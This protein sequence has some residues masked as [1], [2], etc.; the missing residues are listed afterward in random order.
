MQLHER[1]LVP[2]K[3]SDYPLTGGKD[4]KTLIYYL[5]QVKRILGKPINMDAKSISEKLK[6]VMHYHNIIHYVSELQNRYLE[7]G[8][9]IYAQYILQLQDYKNF[10]KN[11]TD[12]VLFEAMTELISY[13]YPT[14]DEELQEVVK[15]NHEKLL[16]LTERFIKAYES[17]NRAAIS[18]SIKNIRKQVAI[19]VKLHTE[20]HIDLSRDITRITKLM[21]VLHYIDKNVYGE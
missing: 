15:K 4:D 3:V 21:S 6:N 10:A 8:E 5:N 20:N 2:F 18:S 1:A 11:E 7:N 9:N 17:G 14:I 13:K 16:Y 12:D 19:L